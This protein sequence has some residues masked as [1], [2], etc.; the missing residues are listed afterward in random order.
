MKV[1]I[2]CERS[3]IIRD[4]F[5]R[6]GHQAISCDL[7]PSRRPGPH[8]QG[9][10]RE[11]LGESWDLLIA[12]PVCRYMANSGVRWL[13]E[14]PERWALMLDGCEFFKLFDR[15]KHIRYRCVENPIIHKYA[16]SLIGRR[17]DQ[18][19]H[20]HFF[21]DPFSK[22]TGLWLTGLP[23]LKRT[24]WIE[25]AD[26][27]QA[28]WLEPPGPEREERRSETYPAIANAMAEQWG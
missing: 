10:V 8:W 11:I 1:L 2:A 17:A 13:H 24:H 6:R 9:D 22:A 19:V 15:A 26:I 27:R 12:H 23:P 3:G 14:R 25:R 16:L 18:F 20:P 4:Q 5:I 28:C 21:G 7:H